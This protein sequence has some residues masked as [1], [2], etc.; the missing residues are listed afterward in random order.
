MSPSRCVR[1]VAWAT[2]IV[3]VR[4]LMARA[5]L[6]CDVLGRVVLNALSS[7]ASIVHGA[8]TCLLLT[9]RL[10]QITRPI[11]VPLLR[12]SM[13]SVLPDIVVPR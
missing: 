8:V 1:A 6:A 3:G 2:V 10:L 9:V 12:M 5:L 13:A 7:T 4:Y 11:A